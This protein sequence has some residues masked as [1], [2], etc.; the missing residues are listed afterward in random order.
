MTENSSSAPV[1]EDLLPAIMS[2][3]NE[4]NLKENVAYSSIKLKWHSNS[5]A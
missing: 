5:P 3:E 4:L 2:K 1:Y